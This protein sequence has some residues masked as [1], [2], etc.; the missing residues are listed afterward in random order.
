MVHDPNDQDGSSKSGHHSLG[1]RRNQ[2]TPGNH[3]H[4]VGNP[5][6]G[7]ISETLFDPTTDIINGSYSGTALKQLLDLLEQ[8]G[9][10][11]DSTEIVGSGN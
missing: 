1:P 9:L 10:T 11:N 5:R 2:A 6:E 8:Y 3:R 4:I 7:F